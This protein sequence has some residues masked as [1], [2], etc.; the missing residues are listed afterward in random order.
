MSERTHL[1]KIKQSLLLDLLS[2]VVDDNYVP[3]IIIFLLTEQTKFAQD[4]CFGLFKQLFN[5]ERS[6]SGEH[7]LDGSSGRKVYSFHP[8]LAGRQV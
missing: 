5:K 3:Q 4:W 7:P 1:H 2:H 8:C 6:K